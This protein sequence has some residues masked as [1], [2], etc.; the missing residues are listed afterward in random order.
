MTAQSLFLNKKPDA[1]YTL[2]VIYQ[3]R[4]P[5]IQTLKT[6]LVPDF[7]VPAIVQMA[8]EIY[9]SESSRNTPA[10]LQLPVVQVL[11]QNAMAQDADM[12]YDEE[13]STPYSED[14]LGEITVKIDL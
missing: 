14:E 12:Q 2:Q 9:K 10:L 3:R 5:S 13:G 11:I 6:L 7:L 1:D 8:K 4:H